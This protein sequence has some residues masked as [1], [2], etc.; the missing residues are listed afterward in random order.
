IL[1]GNKDMD[2]ILAQQQYLDNTI[3]N[4]TYIEI[5]GGTHYMILSHQNILVPLILDFLK[6][7]ASR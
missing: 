2:S 7:N 5:D 1:Q 3:P 6:A 4:S